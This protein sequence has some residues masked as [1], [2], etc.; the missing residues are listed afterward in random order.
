M[1]KH[2]FTSKQMLSKMS[3]SSNQHFVFI[4]TVCISGVPLDKMHLVFQRRWKLISVFLKIRLQKFSKFVSVLWKR[5]P[6]CKFPLR[7]D[8]VH[9]VTDTAVITFSSSWE[10]TGTCALFTGNSF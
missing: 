9:F 10:N 6:N 3:Q 8:A 5:L 7:K 1:W 4:S 2:F